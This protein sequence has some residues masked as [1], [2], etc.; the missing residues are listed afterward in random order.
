M[1]WTVLHDSAVSGTYV[2]P[3]DGSGRRY[4]VDIS[5]SSV[6]E[7]QALQELEDFL[8]ELF[9][10]VGI[11][12]V[13]GHGVE[14]NGS[15]ELSF[16]QSE[17]LRKFVSKA[18]YSKKS[19]S[20]YKQALIRLRNWEYSQNQDV[21]TVID[22][23]IQEIDSR[24][25]S[26]QILN[27]EYTE[28]IDEW[29]LW[30]VYF[31]VNKDVQSLELKMLEVWWSDVQ[32]RKDSKK[33]TLD[34]WTGILHSWII[35]PSCVWA[36]DIYVQW[37]LTDFQGKVEYTELRKIRYDGWI[38]SSVDINEFNKLLVSTETKVAS[39]EG[40]EINSI[41]PLLAVITAINL[42]A[43]LACLDDV[44]CFDILWVADD[45]VKLAKPIVVATKKRVLELSSKGKVDTLVTKLGDGGKKLKQNL[46]KLRVT[47]VT[48]YDISKIY[49]TQPDS[50]TAKG[51]SSITD[52]MK[53]EWFVDNFEPIK[54][55]IDNGKALI[56]D[57]HH[58][59]VAAK[60]LWYDRVPVQYIQ[61]DRIHTITDRTLEQIRAMSFQNWL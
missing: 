48:S 50:Q 26:L 11:E 61:K 21:I 16:E 37:K 58:S 12:S 35:S 54:V 3:K 41:P 36:C 43:Q 52:S 34:E 24:D 31:E 47:K 57:W 40:I 18:E 39:T 44:W 23:F 27:F 32:Y 13:D 4:S 20:K 10:E 45:V 25:L 60:N 28:T 15:F 17:L 51:L 59:Y 2:E 55:Y 22:A 49:K 5:G 46:F 30:G 9:W 1:N 19:L 42:V 33:I 6:V 14:I 53:N 8:E 56:L 38:G 7:D 29:Y